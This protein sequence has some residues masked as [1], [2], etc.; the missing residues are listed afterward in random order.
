[1]SGRLISSVPWGSDSE[2]IAYK[3]RTVPVGTVRCVKRGPSPIAF[4]TIVACSAREWFAKGDLKAKK[5]ILSAI[6]SNL[7][8]KD[9]KLFIEAKNPFLILEKSLPRIHAV[10]LKFEPEKIGSIKAQSATFGVWKAPRLPGQDDVRTL[11]PYFDFN[12]NPKRRKLAEDI[13]RFF[14]ECEILRPAEYAQWK[15]FFDLFEEYQA[16]AA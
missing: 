4:E 11:E 14:I 10:Q 12:S 1:L 6:G 13:A 2:V 15:R 5:E 9:K 3:K 16:I 7:T 8:L